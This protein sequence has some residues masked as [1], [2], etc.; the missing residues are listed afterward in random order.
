MIDHTEQ[1][2]HV[3]I[4]SETMTQFQQEG[5]AKMLINVAYAFNTSIYVKKPKEFTATITVEN[6]QEL[7]Q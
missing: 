4:E 6:T 3:H 5:L 7:N 1:D 2:V